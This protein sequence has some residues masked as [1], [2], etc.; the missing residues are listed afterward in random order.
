MKFEINRISS[1]LLEYSKTSSVAGIRYV[2]SSV[3]PVLGNVIWFFVISIFSS[4][5]VYTSVLS[6]NEWRNEPVL[7]TVAT[8]GFPVKEI[9]FPAVVICPNGGDYE[10]LFAGLYKS[11]F[12][13]VNKTNGIEIKTSPL[14]VARYF[15]QRESQVSND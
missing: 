13:F 1:I 4:L 8:T 11:M 6:F 5:F 10:S 2:F 3:E 14:K 9:S 15:K 7:T 12:D